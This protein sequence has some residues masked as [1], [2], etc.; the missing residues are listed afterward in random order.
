LEDK[1][2]PGR[3]KQEG[4]AEMLPLLYFQTT[5]YTRDEHEIQKIGN[6]YGNSSAIF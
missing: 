5:G 4:E 3:P 1:I 6:S 2:A